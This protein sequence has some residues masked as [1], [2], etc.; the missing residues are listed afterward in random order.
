M[1]ER[2]AIAS[3]EEARAYLEHPILGPR[4]RDCA[5]LVT[6]VKD[7]SI[8]EILGRPDD[9]KF[10]SCMT[11]FSRAAADTDLFNDALRKYFAGSED[12]ATIRALGR[13]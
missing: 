2:F 4:L 11:L 10:R 13:A 5:R 8:T 7:R 12:P 3:I 1:A 6:A 9:L